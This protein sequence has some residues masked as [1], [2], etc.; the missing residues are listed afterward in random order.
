VYRFSSLIF[1]SSLFI[2]VP[3][4]GKPWGRYKKYPAPDQNQGWDT[5]YSTV[6]PWLRIAS[7]LIDAVTGAPVR[8]FPT[9][10]SEVVSYREA[11]KTLAPKR[12]SLWEAYK[13][14]MS[15]SQLF[16]KSIYHNL[17]TLSIPGRWLW[18]KET[19][20]RMSCPLVGEK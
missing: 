14:R 4:K 3:G 18:A 8:L 2:C 20:W 16:T 6:P 7:P 12:I 17:P 1:V 11:N 5:K 15:S 10:S 13:I 9:G 19:K